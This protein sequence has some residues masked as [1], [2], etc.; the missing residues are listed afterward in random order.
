LPTHALPVTEI[1]YLRGLHVKILAGHL[2]SAAAPHLDE[3]R[4]AQRS[5]PVEIDPETIID[6]GH[7]REVTFENR[8]RSHECL[9]W[10]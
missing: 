5:D 10:P 4:V 8:M 2:P 6:L 9:A 3:H 1:P 7:P